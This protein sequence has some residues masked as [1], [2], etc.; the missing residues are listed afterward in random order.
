M[1]D[2]AHDKGSVQRRAAKGAMWTMTHTFLSL[3]VA[4]IV[5]VV[6]ARVLGVVD[7]G[8]LALLTMAVGIV[9]VIVVSGVDSAMIQ[10]GAKA[11]ARN[12]VDAVRTMLSRVQ[13]FRLLVLAPL[14]SLAVVLLVDVPLGPLLLVLVFGIWAPA[15]LSGAKVSLTLEQRTDIDAK[16]QLFGGLV[17]QAAVLATLLVVSTADAVWATR[18]VC[19]GL[20]LFA[21]LPFVDPRY[22]RAVLRPRV[23]LGLGRRFWMFSVQAGAAAIISS[24]VL[25]RSEVFLLEAL[26]D[27]VQLGLFAMAFGLAGHMLAPAQAL[28]NPIRPA[29]AA[30]A[31]TDKE[32]IGEAFRRLVRVL[33][34]LTGVLVAAGSPAVAI[35]APLIYGS[36]YDAAPPLIVALVASS[37]IL[38][39]TF[40]MQAFVLAR[41]RTGSILR[42]N[43]ASMVVAVLVAVPTIVLFGAWGAVASKLSIAI[44]RLA[45][46][47]WIERSSFATSPILAL[48]EMLPLL[49]GLLAAWVGWII[50]GG[51][52]K[53]LAGSLVGAVIGGLVFI[54]LLR[55]SRSGLTAA[56][57]QATV[58]TLPKAILGV[59]STGALLVTYR[60]A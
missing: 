44:T 47:L 51:I 56:D 42:M 40:P 2:V 26:A 39:M 34:T 46:L 8:R 36:E 50:G 15:G 54:A 49:F 52:A 38:L 53:V 35:V 14:S 33:A 3:P 6:L 45:Y 37:S 19:A 1:N 30:L 4:F 11:H 55:W 31:E 32:A 24:L 10:Y 28:L 48:R 21:A 17:K 13:G 60:Q 58:A 22:R 59:A 23:P 16:L 27:P 7:Y 29:V 9:G 20:L 18:V 41:L 12:E 57:A 43:I 25:S 5:N